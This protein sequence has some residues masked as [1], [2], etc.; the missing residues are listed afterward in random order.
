MSETKKLY[1]RS[2]GSSMELKIVHIGY[3]S[4][5]GE[6]AFRYDYK[7]KKINLFNIFS[8]DQYSFN[9]RGS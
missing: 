7:C 3:H 9:D 6:K 5:S 4:E 2:C 1:C 8:H